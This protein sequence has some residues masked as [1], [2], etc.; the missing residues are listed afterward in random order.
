MSTQTANTNCLGGMQCPKCKIL[1]P[2]AIK[3][4]T[5]FRVFDEGTDDQV[6]AADW[7]ENSYCECCECTFTGT[8]KDFTIAKEI[9]A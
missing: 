6:R 7:D 4:P 8:V 3:V 5:T 1:E 2:F 9:A